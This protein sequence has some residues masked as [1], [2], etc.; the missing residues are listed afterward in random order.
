[1]TDCYY[2]NGALLPT[3]DC[4]LGV[5]DRS[6]L[7]GDGLFE[8]MLVR[9]G[10]PVYFAEHLQ[11]L[12]TSCVAFDYN[13][14][15]QD[16]LTDSVREVI[17]ANAL[18]AAALRLT[19]SP[20]ESEGL[21][22]APDSTLN[23]LIT[24]RRGEQYTQSLYERGLTA[25]I[26]Q[27]TRRNEQSPLSRHKTTNFM[28]SIL[29][30][31]E[32]RSRNADEAILLNTKGHLAEGSVSNLFLIKDGE[33]L[34]PRIADGALP[35]IIRGKVL[36]LCKEK[37]LAVRETVLTPQDFKQADE[38]FLTN[39]LLGIMPLFKAESRVL[40]SAASGSL[41]CTLAD[42]FGHS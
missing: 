30:R 7:L 27:T 18:E 24:F 3:T 22:C 40:D 25:L 32:A 16:K 31:K 36:E 8:T 20:Q 21:L 23:I 14:P 41:T 10:K 1:M 28:D 37:G 33:I 38:A 35:G 19:I 42:V 29:A 12:L 34:T 26:A 13:A 9:R 17:E 6:Y 15:S 39:S 2:L 4:R 11:R 5:T